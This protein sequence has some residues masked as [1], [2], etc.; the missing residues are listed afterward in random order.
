MKTYDEIT[1]ADVDRCLAAAAAVHESYPVA[2]LY[3]VPD[4]GAAIGLA[5]STEFGLGANAWTTTK[6]NG[7]G[8]SVTWRPGWCS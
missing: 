8:L 2:M 6:P 1:E 3:P 4:I 5:N 7:T